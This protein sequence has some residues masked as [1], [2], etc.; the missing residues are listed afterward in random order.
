M[1]FSWDVFWQYLLRPSD[2]Y[3]Y[4]PQHPGPR[5]VERM[6]ELAIVGRGLSSYI[7]RV[8]HNDYEA[9]SVGEPPGAHDRRH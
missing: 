2:I 6:K 1:N 5:H 9:R 3:L 4:G 8:V 7:S